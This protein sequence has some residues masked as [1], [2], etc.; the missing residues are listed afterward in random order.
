MRRSL[1][2]AAVLMTG[3]LMLSP[4]VIA[5]AATGAKSSH[6][7][8][9]V[10][11]ISQA[12]YSRLNLTPDQQTKVQ[13]A[14]DTYRADMEKARSLTAPDQKKEAARQ[15]HRAYRDAIQAVLTPDQQNQLQSMMA[16]AR[17]YHNL[18]PVG[19]QLVGLN[20]TSEQQAKIKEIAARHQPDVEKLQSSLKEAADKKPIHEQIRDLQGKMLDEVKAVL[21]PEQV[22]QLQPA[23]RRLQASK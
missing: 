4:A 14:N 7:G 6:Q 23:G 13:A 3:A 21:T 10:A 17:E 1:R 19:V 22:A 18:G 8:H 15:A 16:E 20:L 9:G 11:V 5:S 12:W 2:L